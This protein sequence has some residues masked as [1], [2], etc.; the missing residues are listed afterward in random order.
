MEEERNDLPVLA[1]DQLLSVAEQA[2]KRI[3]AVNKIKKL[4]LRVTNHLDWTNQGGKPYLQVSGQEKV[5]R[6]FGISWII[7]EPILEVEADGH[8]SFT[9]KGTFTFG[10]ATVEVIGT[11]SSRDVFFTTRYKDDEKVTLTPS[12]VDRADVKKAALTNCIGNGISRILGIRNMT[13]N[14]LE[15]AGI[16]KESVGKVEY[17]K[18][19]GEDYNPGGSAEPP[20][21]QTQTAQD[22]PT[23][24]NQKVATPILNVTKKSGDKDGKPWTVFTIFGHLAGNETA[25]K[26]FDQSLADMAFKEKGTGM[27]FEIEYQKGK[28][29][30]DIKSMK[31]VEPEGPAQ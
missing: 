31:P 18:K 30:M 29:G 13:W 27:L 1:N 19:A 12:E 10:A 24:G 6:L 25:F 20:K 3:D 17:K 23:N 2:E 26:T 8:Y 15:D 11:R 4:S 21:P 28:Y 5:A 22:K 9:Y 7:S 16:K 14:D